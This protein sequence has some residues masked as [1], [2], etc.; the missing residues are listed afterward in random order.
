M[1]TLASSGALLAGGFV[2]LL[3]AGHFALEAGWEEAA[4]ISLFRTVSARTAG[5]NIADIG[6]MS[7]A[8]A[9][10]LMFL[11]FIGGSPGGMAGGI[12][13]TTMA[14]AVLNLLRILR[15]RRDVTLFRRRIHENLLQR[16]FAVVLLSMLW[17]VGA[18]GAVMLAQPELDF[19]S[20]LFE[21][22]GAFATVGLSRGV[23][24]ELGAL[25]KSVMILTM[26]VGRVGILN[27]LLSLLP[28][29]AEPRMRL[30]T[31]SVIVE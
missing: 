3:L 4:W 11:M 13:T 12:K 21:T 10:V 29:T 5:F 31:G 2:L 18:S 20:T 28:V 27:F 19:L 8:G 24:S 25:G 9:A 23:T 26:L 14:V 16:A 1:S 7:H 15:R 6:A 22:V 30:P 17:I